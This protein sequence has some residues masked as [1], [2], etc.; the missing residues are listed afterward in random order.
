MQRIV[1]HVPAA[2]NTQATIVLLLETVFSTWSVQRGFKEDNWGDPVEYKRLKLGGG[3][4][5]DRSSD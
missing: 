4:A 3:Q 5:Y 1:K 2:K